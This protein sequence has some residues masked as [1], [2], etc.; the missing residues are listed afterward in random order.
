MLRAFRKSDADLV[1]NTLAGNRD[2]FEDLV[3]RYWPIANAIAHGRLT[4][5]AETQDVAQD[6]FVRA[7][8]EL[9]TLREPAKFGPWF[10]TIVRRIS[11]RANERRGREK[12]RVAQATEERVVRPDHEREELRARVRE[13]V[14]E[15]D[16]AYRH[17][18]VL[19]YFAGQKTREIANL[20]D[21]QPS[22]VRKRLQRARE[23]LGARLLQDLSQEDFGATDRT[24]GVMRAIAAAPAAWESAEA[25]GVSAGT[26]V[27]SGSFARMLTT[28]VI[29]VGGA[30]AGLAGWITS[31]GAPEP[32]DDAVLV[33]NA[34]DDD[35]PTSQSDPSPTPTA[36]A[37]SIQANPADSTGTIDIYGTLLAPS[38]HYVANARVVL[39]LR[40][41]LFS[42]T[43]P[44]Y[45]KPALVRRETRSNDDGFF[46]FTG[47]PLRDDAEISIGSAEIFAT[48]QGLFGFHRIVASSTFP[49]THSVIQMRPNSYVEAKVVDS[50]G[51]AIAGAMVIPGHFEPPTPNNSHIFIPINAYFADG[52]GEIR[53]NDLYAGKWTYLV[54]APG[55]APMETE[56]IETG[57]SRYTWELGPGHV[58]AGV[59]YDEAADEPVA[60]V[61]VRLDSLVRHREEHQMV[62]GEDGAYF[63]DTLGGG[64]YHLT[65]DHPSYLL[66]DTRERENDSES[67]GGPHY[68]R[69]GE[70]QE[71]IRLSVPPSGLELNLPIYKGGVLQ[72]RLV[73]VDTG[74]GIPDV[75][76]YAVDSADSSKRMSSQSRTDSFGD[77]TVRGIQQGTVRLRYRPTSEIPAMESNAAFP[78]APITVESG[79][80]VSGIEWP[81]NRRNSISG[82]VVDESGEPLPNA[83]VSV[84]ERTAWESLGTPIEHS[85]AEPTTNAAG[86]FVVYLPEGLEE[87]YV[88]AH[89][90]GWTT[91]FYGPYDVNAGDQDITLV[92]VRS[93]SLG[94]RV[95]DAAGR[96]KRSAQLQIT[97]KDFGPLTVR[98]M[99]MGTTGRLHLSANLFTEEGGVFRYVGLYPT[100]YTIETE[101]NRVTVALNPGDRAAGLEIQE[102]E[103]P[104]TRLSGI[105]TSG[106]E[107]V[108]N[109][110]VSLGRDSSRTDSEGAYVLSPD[111]DAQAHLS[112]S[113]SVQSD[114]MKIFRRMTAEVS[115]STDASQYL[116]V[117]FARGD[118]IIRGSVFRGQRPFYNVEVSVSIDWDDGFTETITCTTNAD[119]EYIFEGL[120]GGVHSASVRVQ[121][122]T[123]YLSPATVEA[124]IETQSGRTTRHIFRMDEIGGARVQVKGMRDREVAVVRIVPGDERRAQLDQESIEELGQRAVIAQQVTTDRELNFPVIQEGLYTVYVGAYDENANTIAAALPSLRVAYALMQIVAD[125]TTELTIDLNGAN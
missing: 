86:A 4:S 104:G 118:S 102:R 87:V 65:I 89:T 108:R 123:S 48:D 55:F 14:A 99:G 105:V 5:P 34:A 51:N 37:N 96:G 13:A 78:F 82:R 58:L 115:L 44:N 10:L 103:E 64:E 88:R 109:A 106:G 61:T 71:R 6:A 27:I 45:L 3:N 70:N 113:I 57:A 59:V 84:V 121:P 38:G 124:D 73:D 41:S 19:H 79:T 91:Q 72:G 112:A 28:G 21:L 95:V 119:G 120:P 68:I 29:V 93:S 67:T 83:K 30:T 56:L 63:F 20:L 49:E 18:V 80:E 62:T 66:A 31:D 53:I 52:D 43:T 7:Y 117:P 36:A 107:P 1:R 32:A 46:A 90:N 42:R 76:V 111:V 69:V 75:P 114:G 16:E 11:S 116:D 8:Q 50:N 94:G 100:E 47:I 101:G 35:E 15:L 125:E 12:M 97:G 17:V 26:G 85:V 24:K 74:E 40:E 60:D 25:A 9:D 54:Q 22:A 122:D 110:S 92:A 33:A 98:S 39:E 23:M 2:A 77:F 81:V